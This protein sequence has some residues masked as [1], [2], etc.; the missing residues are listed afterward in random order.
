MGHMA[1]DGSDRH[2]L[3]QGTGDAYSAWSPDGNWIAC[4]ST[5]N[6]TS[7]ADIWLFSPS[8]AARI[9]I[10]DNPG[11]ERYPAWSPDGTKIVFAADWTGNDELWIASD[12]F[13]GTP[14]TETTWGRVK[15]LFR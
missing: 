12:L 9:R 8:G 15:A 14:V 11:R 6:G 2:I 5:Q 7:S 10:T 3:T 4:S 13:G 1:V